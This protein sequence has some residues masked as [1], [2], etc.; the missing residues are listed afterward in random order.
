ML[1]YLAVLV[2]YPLEL[3]STVAWLIVGC[4]CVWAVLSPSIED[5]TLERIALS[6]I[7]ISSFSAAFCIIYR[8]MVYYDVAAVSVSIAFYCVTIYIKHRRKHRR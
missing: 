6:L 1:D 2:H 8:G 4:A 7:S 3:V 5:T